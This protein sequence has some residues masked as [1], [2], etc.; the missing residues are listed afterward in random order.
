MNRNRQKIMAGS[1]DLDPLRRRADLGFLLLVLVLVFAAWG[2][3]HAIDATNRSA[4]TVEAVNEAYN[5]ERISSRLL[6]LDDA[7]VHTADGTFPLAPD[8]TLHE[9]DG[10]YIKQVEGLSAY[11][12]GPV[13]LFLRNGRVLRVVAEI[14]GTEQ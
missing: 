14:G 2:D 7:T 5:A 12:G 1:I 11:Y 13:E 10:G 4:G 8:A 3:A 9:R 6:G